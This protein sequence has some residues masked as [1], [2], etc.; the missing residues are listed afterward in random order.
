[1]INFCHFLT[2][3]AS[4]LLKL[5]KFHL[6][7]LLSGSFDRQ[8]FNGPIYQLS[9]SFVFQKSSLLVCQRSVSHF[10]DFF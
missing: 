9:Y 10:T 1:L 3:L 8:R 2:E 7:D 5:V 4:F 6:R